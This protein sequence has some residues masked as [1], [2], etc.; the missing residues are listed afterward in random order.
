MTRLRPIVAVV[1]T[2]AAGAL[3]G[4]V[5]TAL[6][7]PLL[8]GPTQPGNR[9]ELAVTRDYILAFISRDAATVNALELPKNPADRAVVR[10]SFNQALNLEPTRLTYLGGTRSGEVGAYVYILG[11]ETP[12]ETRHLV[13]IVLTTVGSKVGDLRGGSTGIEEE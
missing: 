12:D 3:L 11:V 5:L 1:G 6:V 13:P 4:Y 10:K 8:P 9:H 2:V 7:S